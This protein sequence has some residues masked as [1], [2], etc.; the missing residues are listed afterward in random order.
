MR[1]HAGARPAEVAGEQGQVGNGQHVLGAVRVLGD[2]HR[3]DDRRGSR[4]AVQARGFDDLV[5]RHARDLGDALGRVLVE[6]PAEP[7]EALGARGDEGFVGES[8]SEDDVH[9]AVDQRHVGAR[10]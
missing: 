1:V 7:L 5:G 10:S 2:A 8:L 3:V 9:E 4:A 6:R